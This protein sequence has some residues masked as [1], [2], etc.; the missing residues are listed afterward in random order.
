MAAAH[1]TALLSSSSN[2]SGSSSSNGQQQ[3]HQRGTPGQSL[4]VRCNP[5]SRVL[6][7]N[8]PPFLV[9]WGSGILLA[10]YTRFS[11]VKPTAR[12]QRCCCNPPPLLLS[13]ESL[14][15]VQPRC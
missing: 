6:H 5:Y 10:G 2:G 11:W 1:L 8:P 14:C 9:T 12:S 3:H 15:N 7:C 13:E 4:G